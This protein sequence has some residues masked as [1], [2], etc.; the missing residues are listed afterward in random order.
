[1]KYKFNRLAGI[2]TV[3]I[4]AFAVST[5]F[6]LA[7]SPRLIA[8][9]P[10]LS[11]DQ[12]QRHVIDDSKPWRAV[13]VAVADIDGNT[14]PDIVTGGWW[15]K[16]PGT[17][18][19]T[20]TRSTIGTPLNNIAT[21]Y[22]FDGDGDIDIL[23]TEHI[24]EWVN[25]VADP[26]PFTWAR[27]NGSGQFTLLNNID[28]GYG[29]FLQGVNVQH[30]QNG[31][32][33]Q[34][35]L[36]WQNPGTDVGI[37]MLTVPT[38]TATSTWDWQQISTTAQGEALSAGDIDRDGDLDLLL[39]TKWLQNNGASWSPH[40]LHNTIQEVDR[41]RL[42]DIN[43]DGRLDAVVGYQAEST[44][45]AI[46]WYE[47]GNSATDLWTERIIK[48]MV[49][50]MSLD[51]AD[52]DGD[53]DLDVIVGE[54]NIAAPQ[55]A[56]LYIFENSDGTGTSWAEHI[57]FTGDEHHDGTQVIDI[58]QDGD[59]DIVSIGWSHSNVLVYENQAIQAS[60]TPTP[61]ISNTPISTMTATPLSTATPTTMPS[62]TSTAIPSTTPTA[63]PSV[64][65]TATP[66]A[67]SSATATLTATATPTAT[68]TATP[69]PTTT[70]VATVTPSS[71]PT[72]VVIGT[73]DNELFL[74]LIV[75]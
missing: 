7:A 4:V 67:T 68:T 59:L 64:T 48:N 23:G 18:A 52:M 31:G 2:I 73:N 25:F 26:I 75:K 51:V 19:G 33:L 13:F 47:Q 55:T 70:T 30:F 12:W 28:D 60:S 14:F 5:F 41:N 62:T 61:T 44:L 49:G 36:A 16:N 32:P 37:Q 34:V 71:T 69:L 43:G 8:Q 39:G 74:P 72:T 11:L 42:V 6:W 38:D 46:A 1:M 9:S 10:P 53:G 35:A 29:N 22:D 54:H 57:V 21:V 24:N 63:I 20:W 56:K 66:T 27:N 17:A 65:T 40:T 58:D 45:A 50:P 15:Y 3:A